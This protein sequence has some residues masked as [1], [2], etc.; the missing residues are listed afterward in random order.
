[1]PAILVLEIQVV[2][3]RYV[4]QIRNMYFKLAMVFISPFLT[5][6]CLECAD[7]DSKRDTSF[8]AVAVGAVSKHAATPETL[9]NQFRISVI[10]YEGTGCRNLRSG[11]PVV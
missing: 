11:F 3:F 6:I 5:S 8:A 10:V 1:M 4:R 9:C 2:M 7:I